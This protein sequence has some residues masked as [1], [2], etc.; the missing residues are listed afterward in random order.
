MIFY[1]LTLKNRFFSKFYPHK[2]C[3][4]LNK[5]KQHHFNF[6]YSSLIFYSATAFV[7]LFVWEHI[8]RQ[9]GTRIRPSVGLTRTANST[10]AVCEKIGTIAA[11]VSSFYAR[12][13]WK[14]VMVTFED[15][16][17]PTLNLCASPYYFI[18]GYVKEMNIYEHPYLVGAGTLTLCALVFLLGSRYS[19]WTRMFDL[20]KDMKHLTTQY[21]MRK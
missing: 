2:V 15:L 9:C 4:F 10:H 11:R 17:R 12:I 5:H 14:E 13:K 1:L 6:M 16:W 18:K 19:V 7:G 3:H 8:G 21:L 20:S